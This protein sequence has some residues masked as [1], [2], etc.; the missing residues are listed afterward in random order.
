MKILKYIFLLLLLTAV[1]VTV[2]LATQKGDFTIERSR[3]IKAPK[4]ALFNYINDYK[5]WEDFGSWFVDNPET[6][7]QLGE[8]TSGKNGSL[9]WTNN[10]NQGD[11]KTL[12]I[13]NTD[14]IRQKLNY[15]GSLIDSQISFK[16]T[17]GGTKVTW[18]TKGEMSFYLK[19]YTAL[20]GGADKIIGTIYEKTLLNLDKILV[21]ET[22]TYSIKV[23]GVVK[24]PEVF[25]IRQTFTTEIA[26]I[27]RNARI[28]IPKLA[29]FSETNGIA[30]NGKPFIIYHTYDI[31]TGLAK[32]SVCLPINK[33]IFT[34]S[35]SDILTGKLTAFEAVKTTINGDYSHREEAFTKTQQFITTE[36]LSPDTTWSHLEVYVMSKQ[37]VKNPSKWITEIYYPLKEKVIPV[38]RP[39]YRPKPTPEPEP[40]RAEPEQETS[41]F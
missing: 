10:D 13:T 19:V 27:T 35:G 36:K 1:T 23:N 40:Q 39:V 5:N 24:K 2:F 29:E 3:V 9:S 26:K 37:D 4:T 15:D 41:E 20:N 16:D 32:I 7:I 28:V 31:E 6:T 17:V 33:E 18:K 8:T 14:E 38:A 25:Y 30:S 34:S 12:G 22:N 11:M 21:F